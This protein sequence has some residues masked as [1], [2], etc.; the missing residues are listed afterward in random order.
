MWKVG[1]IK[2]ER[3]QGRRIL[4][5]MLYG[6]WRKYY[7]FGT[8]SMTTLKFGGFWVGPGT[9]GWS[10][11]IDIQI[12]KSLFDQS[13]TDQKHIGL[14]KNSQVFHWE[15]ADQSMKSGPLCKFHLYIMHCN[16]CH[17][18]LAR[19]E[20]IQKQRTEVESNK[21]KLWSFRRKS[22]PLIWSKYLYL[23]PIEHIHSDH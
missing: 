11:V 4:F 10:L 3:I 1:D 2:I 9:I 13:K 12:Q 21:R 15:H 22:G 6:K 5:L 16:N 19:Y 17:K 14:S 20:D 7:V 8:F 23:D 18:R